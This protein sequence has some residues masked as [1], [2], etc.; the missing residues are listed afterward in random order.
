MEDLKI[1]KII[2]DVE[3]KNKYNYDVHQ[4]IKIVDLK[5]MLDTALQMSRF[6]M[7]LFH[8]GEEYTNSNDSKIENLFP[9][10]KEILFNVNYQN[11]PVQKEINVFFPNRRYC[12]KH[13][14]KFLS[15]FCFDCNTSFCS[16][17][18]KNGEHLDHESIEK[19]DYLLDSEIIVERIFR[20]TTNDIKNI[21]TDKN[22][23]IADLEKKIHEIFSELLRNLIIKL[24]E[25][26]RSLLK[27]YG[28]TFDSSVSKL[29]SNFKRMKE[30]CV[31]VLTDKK[32]ELG[33]QKLIS[34]DQVV[35]SYYNTILQIYNQRNPFNKEILKLLDLEKSFENV[36]CFIEK[37]N[38]HLSNLLNSTINNNEE[39][40]NCQ[41][42]IRK[43]EIK[44]LTKE[45]IK[46]N[47]EMEI[48]NHKSNAPLPINDYYQNSPEDKNV[49][50]S[51][52]KSIGKKHHLDEITNMAYLPN[53]NGPVSR[54]DFTSEKKILEKKDTEMKDISHKKMQE[55]INRIGDLDSNIK[56]SLNLNTIKNQEFLR[57]NIQSAKIENY[58]NKET[59]FNNI[60][61]SYKDNST[62]KVKPCEIEK[63]NINV[64]NNNMM[65]I[66]E[67]KKQIIPENNSFSLFN[68]SSN[69][70]SPRKEIKNVLD[71]S[72]AEL[73]KKDPAS[74]FS[75]KN[76]NNNNNTQK[77]EVKNVLDTPSGELTKNNP[78]SIFSSK[79]NNNNNNTQK[80]EVKNVLDT[81]S[82]ELT[83][84]N[85]ESIF[86]S[87]NNNYNNFTQ[88]TE[89]KN[90]LDSS[91]AELAKKNPASLFSSKIDNNNFTQKT[92]QIET[93]AV[94]SKNDPRYNINYTGNLFNNFLFHN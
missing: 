28:E 19:Y 20:K 12:H 52:F 75:S 63:E 64:N 59:P 90:V 22:K 23:I 69:N 53:Y 91:T 3:G 82:G 43:T 37:T 58:S 45:K 4:G 62:I 42:E 48:I 81:P 14:N 6:K 88:K 8:E 7:N 40:I 89:V 86:S 10:K 94:I 21:K 68:P 85:P 54:I 2:F 56:P 29:N 39:Y 35:I 66:E 51:A 1:R 71:T 38:G 25:R 79:N 74:I 46:R 16:V 70:E 83:K 15:H 31:E 34:D 27:F 47:I 11:K 61:V 77:T 76:N 30:V 87:K 57:S 5:R 60:N 32:E 13:E 55:N 49:T 93:P 36:N 26:S 17:C 84:N 50:K 65:D 92:S 18:H 9:D 33:M 73:A 78:E 24:E 41:N 80:T 44:E 67:E 72:A